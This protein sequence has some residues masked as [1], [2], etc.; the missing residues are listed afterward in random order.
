M[1]GTFSGIAEAQRNKAQQL[2]LAKK[3]PRKMRKCYLI[4]ASA[5]RNFRNLALKVSNAQRNFRNCTFEVNEAQRNFR[6]AILKWSAAQLPQ[7][8]VKVEH[9]ATFL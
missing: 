4:F 2:W 3:A 1:P 6:H 8:I 9:R 7:H 5:Q